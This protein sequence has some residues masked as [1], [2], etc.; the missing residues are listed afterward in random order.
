MY[1]KQQYSLLYNFI[2]LQINF[3]QFCYVYLIKINYYIC[4]PGCK[5]IKIITDSE[6]TIN[7]MTKW[8]QTWKKKGWK[9]ASGEPVKNKEDLEVLDK[10]CSRAKI[11]WVNGLFI[12]ASLR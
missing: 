5:N 2:P 4:F 9:K 8:V 12:I 3:L 10:L 1:F 11:E 6:F 7:C